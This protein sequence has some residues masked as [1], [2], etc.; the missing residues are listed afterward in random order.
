MK[1]YLIITNSLQLVK[2]LLIS[3]MNSMLVTTSRA[4]FSVHMTSQYKVLKQVYTSKSVK[5]DE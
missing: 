4:Y 3:S 5:G 1:Y 2:D